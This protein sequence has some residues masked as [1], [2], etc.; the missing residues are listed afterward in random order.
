MAPKKGKG[1]KKDSDDGKTDV[2][3]DIDRDQ[4]LKDELDKLAKE[5]VD[6]KEKVNSLKQDNEWLE[7]EAQR[8][9]EES[10]EYMTF[11]AKKASSR[12]NAIITLSD[13][14]KKEIEDIKEEKEKSIAEFEAKKIALQNNLIA[15]QNTLNKVKE[16]ID[17]MAEYKDLK[18][19][20]LDEIKELETEISKVRQE[21]TKLINSMREQFLQ[22]KAEHK[23]STDQRIA[24]IVKVANREARD[25]LNK[26]TIMIRNENQDLRSELFGLIDETNA[27]QASKKRLEKQKNDLLHEIKYAE[28]LKKVRST[29]QKRVIE[30]LFPDIHGNGL[31][32]NDDKDDDDGDVQY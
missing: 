7:S 19:K 13:H 5:L 15:K 22:E 26:N 8:I 23:R 10:Q 21:Q 12:Q 2:D 3:R 9:S 20:Q 29:Q 30:R 24:K 17:E 25:C 11:M 14:N 16:E 1:K 32:Q 31:D 4:Q 6:T 28:D 27:I 18:Q